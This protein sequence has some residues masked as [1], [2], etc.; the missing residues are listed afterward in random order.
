MNPGKP[1]TAI[2]MAALAAISGQAKQPQKPNIIVMLADDLGYGDISA[3]NPESKLQTPNIDRIANEG[4]SFTDAHSSSSVS[5]PSRYG[6]LTGRYNWRSTLKRGVVNGYQGP[7]LSEGRATMADM[8]H[9]ADYQ[10]ACIG[11]WHLGWDWP[12][13]E[14]GTAI[15]FSKPV[16]RGPVTNG[17]DYFFGIVASLD[18]PPFVYVQNDM[19]TTSRVLDFEGM[20]GKRMM[21]SGPI[22]DDFVPEQVL[23]TFVEKARQYIAEAAPKDEP[24]FL[25]LPFSAPHTPILPTEE[26]QGK[27]GLNEY[28][29]FV[30]MVDA[31]VG[32]VLDAVARSGEEDNT[33][34]VF[35]SDNGCSPAADYDELLAK[36][37]NPSAWFRGHKADLFDGGHRVPMVIRWG[38]AI[39]PH[40]VDQTVCYTDLYRTFATL[41]GVD[42]PDNEGEDSFDISP[43]LLRKNYRKPIREYVIHHSIN[44]EFSVRKGD[45]KLL[46]SK[47]SGGWSYPRDKSRVPEWDGLPIVQLYDMKTDVAEQNNLFGQYPEVV[48]ELKAIML[49]AV[50]QGRTTPGAPQK[51]ESEE[52][53]SQLNDLKTICESL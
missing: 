38:K 22:G 27:S 44:G 10:T 1:L 31:M 25:Y 45:W 47:G 4:V 8:L 3:L 12:K 49:D 51:N 28:G 46:F 43:L 2:G 24:Y 50:K 41:A 39:R 35:L 21:R 11:K 26:F 23:P 17:F 42:V 14:D 40:V 30:L 9:R 36:G 29:D 33:I 16:G 5:T 32:R 20:K 34:V 13:A 15:D 7:V 52:K 18:Y 6:L 53:W 48:S 37:H 19:P